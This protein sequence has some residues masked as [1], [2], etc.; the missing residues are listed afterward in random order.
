MMTIS[1]STARFHS[2]VDLSSDPKRDDSSY[3][4]T[5]AFNIVLTYQ[6][7]GYIRAAVIGGSVCGAMTQL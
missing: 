6:T 3:K 4:Q 1:S 7:E 2:Q 5:T